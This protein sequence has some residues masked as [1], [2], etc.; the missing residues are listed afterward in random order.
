MSFAALSCVWLLGLPP[1]SP[2][3]SLTL[4]I[5]GASMLPLLLPLALG[6]GGGGGAAP[7]PPSRCSRGTRREVASKLD[8]LGGRP[9]PGTR[10]EELRAGGGGGGK[11]LG[12]EAEC[13]MCGTAPGDGTLVMSPGNAAWPIGERSASLMALGLVA[14]AAELGAAAVAEAKLVAVGLMT[15]FEALLL[16]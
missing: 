9:P 5:P 8:T 1:P 4:P 10:T 13:C 11:S 3:S 15:E 6:L 14:L 7:A 16:P 2:V 12:C